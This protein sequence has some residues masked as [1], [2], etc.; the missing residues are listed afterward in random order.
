MA[1]LCYN[2]GCGQKFDPDKNKDGKVLLHVSAPYFK[3]GT[4]SDPVIK[5]LELKWKK[6]GCEM[7]LVGC[8]KNT[9]FPS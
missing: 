5:D 2:K 8:L 6:T 4:M 7:T 1:L 9:E 3:P